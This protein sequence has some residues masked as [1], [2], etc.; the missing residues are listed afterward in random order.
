VTRFV[1]ASDDPTDNRCV[2]ALTI[3]IT[4]ARDPACKR[5]LAVNLAASLGRR[6]TPGTRVCV[7]DADP[8]SRDVTTRLAAAGSSLDACAARAQGSVPFLDRV[9]SVCDPPLWVLPRAGTEAGPA[10][11]P[12]GDV[13]GALRTQF[14]LVVCDL[15]CGPQSALVP[16]AQLVG[17]DWVLLAV[18]P[19]R[20]SV[21]AAVCFLEQFGHA[22]V[23][24]DIAESVQLGVVTT[25]DETS[26]E[27]S[28]DAVSTMLGEPVL[29]SVPQLWGR[30]APNVG[31]GAA[32]GI[33]ELDDAVCALFER[34]RP[35]AA[36]T[37]SR[38][39]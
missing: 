39:T 14:D 34:L 2:T 7:V 4:T 5:G 11:R 31:F 37:S 27:L 33:D 26:T 24:G 22:R 36:I 29:A 28:A 13:V 21:E 30:A 17:L 23:L 6:A 3:G 15:A 9:D 18:T 35:A 1:A 20:A 32:L 25:G 12:L 10:Q 38:A 16:S 19:R 8:T